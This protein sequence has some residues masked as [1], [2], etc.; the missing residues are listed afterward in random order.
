MQDSLVYFSLRGYVITY[1]VTVKG[2]LAV[3]GDRDPPE[4]LQQPG[5]FFQDQLGCVHA[6]E[7]LAQRHRE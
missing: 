1:L 6:G 2:T 5:G 4:E 7:K 3:G